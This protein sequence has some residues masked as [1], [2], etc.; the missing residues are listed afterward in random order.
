MS[1]QTVQQSSSIPNG[2]NNTLPLKIYRTKNYISK[3]EPNFNKSY[4]KCE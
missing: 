2:N 3:T 4:G 1:N